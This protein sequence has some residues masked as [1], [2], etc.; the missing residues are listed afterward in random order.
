MARNDRRLHWLAFF[1]VILATPTALI[2][3]LA[4]GG[5]EILNK[6]NALAV[7]LGCLVGWLACPDTCW[8]SSEARQPRIAWPKTLLFGIIFTGFYAAVGFA[9]CLVVMAR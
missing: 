4:E 6:Q 9:G 1:S 7:I 2:A 8:P 5:A 3:L